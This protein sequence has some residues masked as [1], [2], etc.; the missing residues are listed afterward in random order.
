MRCGRAWNDGLSRFHRRSCR[1]RHL[2]RFHLRRQAPA[3]AGWR[4][5]RLGTAG[6]R[7][8]AGRPQFQISSSARHRHSGIRRAERAGDHWQGW[9]HRAQYA[10]YRCR[11]LPGARCG[12]PE[13]LAVAEA[14]YRLAQ[15]PAVAV[16]RGW[17]LLQDLH[18]A[19]GLLGKGLRADHPQGR[20]PRSRCDAGR[21][22][23][24]REILGP[25]RPAGGRRRTDW[26]DGGPYCGARR[27]AR[28]PRRR[29]LSSRGLAAVGKARHRGRERRCLCE[30]RA[31]RTRRLPQRH[32]DAAHDGFRLVRRQCFRRSR[33]GAEA[34]RHAVDESAGGAAVADHCQAGHCRHRGRGAAAGFRRQRPA[35]G[36]DGWGRAQ[37]SLPLRCC[38]R[39]EG[40][41]VHQ[42]WLR[43]SHGARPDRRR[44]RD[45]RDH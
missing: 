16:P 40:C 19:G 4:Y 36:D 3:G 33:E 12:Q 39:P 44:R 25:L 9:P 14:R 34:Y 38:H 6:Q 1:S 27:T 24:I 45:R 7:P 29:R 43:L 18:V 11:T 2:P 5:A 32:A 31:R 35:G 30:N 21:S 8:D 23:S 17:F 20:R 28:H 41:C 10:R 26:A 37:L 15:Q 22:R 13:P 42:W